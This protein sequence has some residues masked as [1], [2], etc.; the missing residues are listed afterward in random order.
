MPKKSHVRPRGLGLMRI[1]Q[2]DPFWI[3]SPL[4]E[5]EL[6]GE[7]F[8]ARFQSNPAC[9]ILERHKAAG[10]NVV[11]LKIALYGLV[12]VRTRLP[13]SRRT[14]E[15]CTKRCIKGL[16]EF[17]ALPGPIMGKKEAE[18]ALRHLE[19]F[20]AS[21]VDQEAYY[22]WWKPTEPSAFADPREAMILTMGKPP[23]QQFEDRGRPQGSAANLLLAC[24][25]HEF[26]LRFNFPHYQDIRELVTQVIPEVFP[27]GTKAA[28]IYQ[29]VKGV[30]PKRR[31]EH[32]HK[33]LFL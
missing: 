26:R 33:R 8:E 1:G 9:Q 5:C 12:P 24:I 32:L 2:R 13:P 11:R 17:L 23:A 16:K 18:A 31:I 7:E 14:L 29:R 4:E 19:F 22:G 6:S 10:G 21:K 20:L 30:E 3:S 25:A 27:P 15:A 28:H